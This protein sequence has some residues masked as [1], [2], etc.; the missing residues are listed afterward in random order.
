MGSREDS[1]RTHYWTVEEETIPGTLEGILTGTRLLGRRNR[2]T[3]PGTHRKVPVSVGQHH[4]RHYHLRPII[5][6]LDTTPT[7]SSTLDITVTSST[8]P[9]RGKRI[10]VAPHQHT[11][12]SARGMDPNHR[13]P[14]GKDSKEISHPYRCRKNTTTVTTR[15]TVTSHR[16]ERRTAQKVHHNIHPN[17]QRMARAL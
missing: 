11:Y 10:T 6:S 12:S 7:L 2:S 9:T 8:L 15:T 13:R 5:D 14:S 1:Q 3:C 17:A 16:R 4:S